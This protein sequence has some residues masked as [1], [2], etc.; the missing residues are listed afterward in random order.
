MRLIGVLLLLVSLSLSNNVFAEGPCVSSEKDTF[1][2]CFQTEKDVGV[3]LMV[4]EK[5][6]KQIELTDICNEKVK[7]CKEKCVLLENTIDAQQN[8]I[9]EYKDAVDNLKQ[10]I[11]SQREAYEKQIKEVKP[12]I[13]YNLKV[14]SIGAI[15]GAI[16]IAIAIIF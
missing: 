14:G 8:E 3:F 12:G 10:V 16:G 9:S 15:L 2:I 5:F 6:Q 11:D 1:T 13:W 4:Y 7:V